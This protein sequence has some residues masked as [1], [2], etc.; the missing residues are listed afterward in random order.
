MNILH[1]LLCLVQIFSAIAIVALVLLQQGKGADM[2]AAF[3]SGA[4]GSLFGASGSA[5]FLSR[6]TAIAAALFFVATIGITWVN[7]GQHQNLSGSVMQNIPANASRIPTEASTPAQSE[8]LPVKKNGSTAAPAVAGSH[9]Q[10]QEPKQQGDVN[11]I[12]Q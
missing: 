11:K 2:G 6:S 10:K 4:S 8:P 3:G 9:V 1:V 7:S 12:P 5:N